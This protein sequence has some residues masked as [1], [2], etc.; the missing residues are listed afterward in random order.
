MIRIFLVLFLLFSSIAHADVTRVVETAASSDSVTN[1][2]VP[3]TNIIF[4][5]SISLVNHESGSVGVMYKATSSG[6]IN[7]TVQAERSYSRPTTEGASDVSYVVWNDPFTMTDNQWHMATLDTVVMPY[8]RFKITG[9]SGNAAFTTIQ[10]KV[11]K[12]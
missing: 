10:L 6:T 11:Q 1:I 4:T 7:L 9:G 3:S 12:Q 2:S 5:K 8:V